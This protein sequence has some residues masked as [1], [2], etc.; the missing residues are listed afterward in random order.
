VLKGYRLIE[1]ECDE[2]WD[3]FVDNSI[4]GTIFSKS[5]YLKALNVNYKLY[6]CYKEKEL[7]AAVSLIESEN[8]KNTILNDFIVY[9]GIMYNKPTTDQ[10]HSQKL[11]EQFRIQEFIATELAV[12]YENIELSLHP[13]VVDVRAFLWIN[14]SDNKPQYNSNIRYT[15]Y[16]D[17]SDFKN[18]KKLEDISIYNKASN[19]RRQQIRY[20]IKKHYQTEIIND[21]GKLVNFY[22]K[23]MNRQGLEVEIKKIQRM[24]GLSS[25]LIEKDMAKI[26]AS[27]DDLGEL[28]SMALFGWDNKRAYYIFGANDPAKRNGHSGTNVLWEAFYDLSKMDINEVDLEGVNSPHRGW[29]KLSFGGDILPYYEINY[30]S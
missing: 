27:Y 20:A 29:F 16:L 23:T 13:S 21:P 22:K 19:S 17:I 28:S 24:E 5:H 30:K 25:K 18:S 7:R 3:R 9:N 12:N 11:S 26:Y 8:K 6:Y 1:A 2:N 14:Y 15:T 4:N 10:N